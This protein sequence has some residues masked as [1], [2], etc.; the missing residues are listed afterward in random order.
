MRI[1]ILSNKLPY[2]PNDG[3]A[4][5]TLNNALGLLETG[6]EVW[7]LCINTNK[8]YFPETEV[9]NYLRKKLHLKSV[10]HDTSVCLF[11]M[12]HNLFLSTKPYNAERFFSKLFSKELQKILLAGKFDLIQLE[13]PFMGWYIP[14]IRRFS[15]ARISLRAH[16]LE[17]EIWKRK[18]ENEKCLF[19]K[20]YFKV[21]ASRIWKFEKEILKQVDM[22][23]TF[24]S[25]EH[26]IFTRMRT[27]IPSK[28]IPPGLFIRNYPETKTQNPDS[29][30]F[31]GALDWL[32]NQQGILWFLDKVWSKYRFPLEL[33]IA[34]R[35]APLKLRKIFSNTKGVIFHGEV[36]NAF[37]F[38]SGYGIMI[39]PVFI[40]SGIRIKILE[41]MLAGKTVISTSVGAEGIM[42]KDGN[43]IH[44]AD[45]PVDF[46]EKITLLTGNP[47]LLSAT[48]S[49]ARRFVIKN[50]DNLAICK[51]LTRFYVNNL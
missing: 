10:K 30:F 33:H 19:L 8:H 32:P 31:I 15:K 16:N 13:S 24:S 20:F 40:G 1:L 27:D 50:F 37:S 47:A 12:L 51:Q 43:E 41:A 44:I 2:P 14:V 25:R 11:K 46:S 49:K 7:L 34:G 35:N 22:L 48:G 36:K 39:C 9:P 21:M 29:L 38:I 18:A 4:I 5:A 6:N 42:V 17:Y 45:S 26:E 28:I 3:G 23:I